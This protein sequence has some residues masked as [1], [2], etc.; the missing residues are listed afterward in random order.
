[1]L[2]PAQIVAFQFPQTDLAQGKLRPALLLARLPGQHNDW[3]TCMIT[4]QLRQYVPE[5]DEFIT[6]T[7]AD[8]P[9]S[10]LSKASV[11]RTSRLA[12]IAAE[13]FV[14]QLGEITPERH[15]RI[16]QRLSDW[17]LTA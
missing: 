3:L 5:L 1:M 7:E 17:L 4:S 15:R 9:L 14:G 16:C 10:G 12:V 8:F 11:I 2:Q 13:I 6:P